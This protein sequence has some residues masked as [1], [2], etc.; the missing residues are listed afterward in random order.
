[1]SGTNVAFN[2]Y[3]DPAWIRAGGGTFDLNSAYLTGAWSDDLQ[4]RVRGYLD[5]VE[6]SDE[7]YTVQSTAP[8]HVVF[9]L[10]GVDEVQFSSGGWHIAMDDLV[11]NETPS[12][13]PA[14]VRPVP[15][16]HPLGLM[17][18]SGLIAGLAVFRRRR[19]V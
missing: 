16:A 1:M 12:G 3:G 11:V 10:F 7:T 17:L 15:V 14:E 8:T 18:L 9:N 19:L 13:P 6:V 5:G 4:V 2:A